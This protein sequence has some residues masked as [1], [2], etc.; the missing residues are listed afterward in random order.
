MDSDEII[1]HPLT[2]DEVKECCKDIQVLGRKE[3]L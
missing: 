3:L 2:T 1:N